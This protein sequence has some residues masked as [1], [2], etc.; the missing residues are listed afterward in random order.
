M[1]FTL[2]SSKILQL[3]AFSLAMCLFCPEVRVKRWNHPK[4]NI[5]GYPLYLSRHRQCFS[6]HPYAY[7]LCYSL[8]QCHQVKMSSVEK[9][10]PWSTT[11][12]SKLNTICAVITNIVNTSSTRSLTLQMFTK[13]SVTALNT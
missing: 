3:Y 4:S 13:Y 8:H 6:M 10:L 2:F 12:L 9:C 1:H 5:Y 11:V 7:N